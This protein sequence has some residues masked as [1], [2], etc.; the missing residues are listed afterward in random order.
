[1]GTSHPLLHT[2]EAISSL[3]RP[4]GF[5]EYFIQ[6][7][8]LCKANRA[9]LRMERQIIHPHIFLL[10]LAAAL[11][12]ICFANRSRL[13]RNCANEFPW[14]SWQEQNQRMYWGMSQLSLAA[15]IEAVWL[16]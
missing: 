7:H 6:V 10:S 3:F 13:A 8:H 12:Q 14:H 11:V 1:M 2:A 5:G 4:L 15:H 9:H 16:C